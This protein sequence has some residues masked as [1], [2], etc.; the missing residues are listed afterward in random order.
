MPRKLQPF[1]PKCGAGVDA[2]IENLCESCYTEGRKL[3]DVPQHVII[4]GCPSCARV[5]LGGKW[6]TLEDDPTLA[7]VFD[8]I[9]I[10]GQAK[11]DVTYENN[12]VHVTAEGHIQ[13]AVTPKREE[14]DL[15]VKRLKRYCDDCTRARGGY[16]EGVL[17]I[18]SKDERNIKR[19]LLLVDHVLAKPKGKYWFIAKTAEVKGGVDVYMGSKTLLNTVRRTIK[20]ELPD[21]ELTSSHELFGK[22]DGNDIYRNFLAVHVV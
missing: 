21:A 6:V 4:R 17:Q 18:R 14:Y 5:Y 12:R 16:F 15:T 11:I 9:K 19:V 10:N 1:C 8:S 20:D 13:E 2:L 3:V 7:A 22:K